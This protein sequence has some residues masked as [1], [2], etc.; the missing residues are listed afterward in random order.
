MTKPKTVD[1]YYDPFDYEIDDD[2]LRGVGQG[3]DQD[4]MRQ[5]R[6]VRAIWRE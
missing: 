4:A 6:G 2:L 1:V 3:A 5:R